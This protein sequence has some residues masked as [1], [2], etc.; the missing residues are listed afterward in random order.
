MDSACSALASELCLPHAKYLSRFPDSMVAPCG[1]REDGNNGKG[2]EVV[3]TPTNKSEEIERFLTDTF[4]HDR[5]EV[6]S[7]NKCVP[8]PIGCGGDASKFKDERSRREY[9]ISGLCQKCQDAFF[10]S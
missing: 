1:W 9:S 6:I 8:K 5:R 7:A 2:S 4:G 10:G 3:M